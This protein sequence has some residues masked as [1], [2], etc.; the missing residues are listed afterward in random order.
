MCLSGW[1]GKRVVCLLHDIREVH[2][3]LINEMRSDVRCLFSDLTSSQT[4]ELVSVFCFR[5]V[6][7]A[8]TE[9]DRCVTCLCSGAVLTWKQPNNL[10]SVKPFEGVLLVC[11]KPKWFGKILVT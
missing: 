4:T 6:T 10:D 7:F 3:F 9:Q 5:V 1:L 11:R 2:S 8:D